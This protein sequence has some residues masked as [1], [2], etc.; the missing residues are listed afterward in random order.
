[1]TS[2]CY[3]YFLNNHT[4]NSTALLEIIKQ[5]S[6]YYSQLSEFIESNI[7]AGAK[8]CNHKSL[9][10][11]DNKTSIIIRRIKQVI[12]TKHKQISLFGIPIFTV[13]KTD[14]INHNVFLF[15]IPLFRYITNRESKSS[16][17]HILPIYW[18]GKIIKNVFGVVKRKLHRIVAKT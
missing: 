7:P 1:M 11:F 4:T 2:K 12:G 10:F 18:A 8:L 5:S 16:T 6:M 15:I 17:F 13:T 14:S 9:N 3:N